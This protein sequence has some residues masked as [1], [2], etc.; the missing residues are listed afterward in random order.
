MGASISELTEDDKVLLEE[1][2]TDFETTFNTRVERGWETFTKIGP[3]SSRPFTGRFDSTPI[4]HYMPGNL[5][6]DSRMM[7]TSTS[8][9]PSGIRELA[10]VLSRVWLSGACNRTITLRPPLTSRTS[11]TP[12]T[13]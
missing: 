10:M 2:I 6:T 13:A 12:S 9:R 4:W 7:R 3:L 5:I 1:L 11:I 8:L